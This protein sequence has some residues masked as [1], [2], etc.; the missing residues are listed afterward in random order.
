MDKIKKAL[1]LI[2]FVVVLIIASVGLGIAPALGQRKEEYLNRE[3]KTEMVDD[4]NEDEEE[5]KE[6]Q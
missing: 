2:G 4:Q 1:R 6:H 5:S 3:V